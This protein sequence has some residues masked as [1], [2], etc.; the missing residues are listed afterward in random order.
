MLIISRREDEKILIGQDIT[1][2]I[3]RIKSGNVLLGI[4]A[5]RKVAIARHELIQGSPNWRPRRK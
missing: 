5:P 1:V 2:T 4:E 3:T